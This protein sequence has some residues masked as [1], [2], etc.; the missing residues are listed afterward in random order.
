S[1]ATVS[2]DPTY[3]TRSSLR[4]SLN[5][6]NL[7][8]FR[9]LITE[10]LPNKKA[11]VSDDFVEKVLT[12]LK[13]KFATMGD[14]SSW[15]TS[16]ETQSW[17][18]GETIKSWTSAYADTY[19]AHF[20]ITICFFGILTNSFNIIILTRK[21]MAAAPINRILAALAW[22]DMFLML[23]YIPFAYY[24]NLEI[25]KNMDFPYYGAVYTLFHT[26]YALILHTVSICL[27]LTLAVW[28]YLAIGFI[29][30]NH[31]LCSHHRCTLAII[32]SF[33]LP[34]FLCMPQYPAL[35]IKS[36]VVEEQN[37]NYTLYH[38]QLS[39]LVE[40]HKTL[41][42]VNFW[43]F[44]IFLKV[45]PCLILMVIS[46][47][48]IR[49][50]FK[51]KKGRQVLKSQDNNFLI[52]P[53]REQN[54]NSTKYERRADRTTKML[55]VILILFLVTELPQGL[56]ALGIGLTGK[57][58]FL[59]CYQSYGEIM[60]ILALLNGSIN[61]LLYC[62]MNRMFRITFGQLFRNKILNKWVQPGASDTPTMIAESQ[63]TVTAT[64]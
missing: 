1:N 27:T 53:S 28:R 49:T 13:Q 39:D 56:F 18:C 36:T 60:D 35:T 52:T 48:L 44:G 64:V 62:C 10:L 12:I 57:D 61:F 37:V 47:W 33:I 45:L 58:L 11:N 21:D 7:T 5:N 59:T 30:K 51:A 2:M 4:A 6:N 50:L 43:L 3:S 14:E 63:K 46:I 8:Y 25:K 9:H 29:E 19:H 40:K 26:H 41:L 42:K 23:E 16:N 55:V 34:L 20:A 38:V 17:F 24:Y 32:I 31:I 54:K 22:A 15:T